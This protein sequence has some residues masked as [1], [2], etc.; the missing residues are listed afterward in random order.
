MPDS[1]FRNLIVFLGL[2]LSAI[3]CSSSRTTTSLL[4][5][6][7]LYPVSETIEEV[8]QKIPDY[9]GS[10]VSAKGKGR[11][12]ISEPGNS[13]RIT[14]QFETDT[15]LSLLTFK[16]RI[17]IE[18]GKM[19][20]DTDSILIYDKIEKRAEKISV[21][22]SELTSINELASLNLLDLMNFKIKAREVERMLQSDSE[23]I[24][25][26]TN[27]GIARINKSDG[28]VNLVQQ[29]RTSGLPYSRIEYEG[30][31][32]IKGYTLPRKIT[33]FSAD[34]RS[35]VV[36]QIRSLEVNPADLELSLEIPDDIPIYRQ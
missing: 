30:Y 32:K 5:D 15:T 27:K 22:D 24:L 20:V 35:K 26:F 7:E 25:G 19:L 12:L 18:G 21:H 3:S 6:Q 11:A 16:N 4:A 23:Y 10:L 34:A 13:D 29:A 31:A 8:I 28:T 36:F 1:S 17:G 33:I 14:I 9:S 2:A